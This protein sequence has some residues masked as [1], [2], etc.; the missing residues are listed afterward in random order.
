MTFIY[1]DDVKQKEKKGVQHGTPRFFNEVDS[2]A[3]EVFTDDV[4]IT[5]EYKA[6]G[7]PVSPI[8]VK[9]KPK[10]KKPKGDSNE[11]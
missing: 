11:L 4:R 2:R 9:P 8:T 1:T 5:K 6:I 10:A 7:I 3:T